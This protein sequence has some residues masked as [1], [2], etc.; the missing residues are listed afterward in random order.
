MQRALEEAG[1]WHFPLLHRPP[2]ILLV[3]F[4]YKA[5]TRI[6]STNEHPRPD[7]A[8]E[9]APEDQQQQ[10]QQTTRRNLDTGEDEPF[11][12]KELEDKSI[13]DFGSGSGG[14][15]AGDGGGA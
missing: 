9:F 4:P 10:P 8:S 6:M 3:R 1:R 11:D 7:S 15:A 5:K 2:G 14:G 12:P 13:M